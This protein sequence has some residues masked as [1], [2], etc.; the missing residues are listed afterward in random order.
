M[1]PPKQSPLLHLNQLKRPSLPTIHMPPSPLRT[2]NTKGTNLSHQTDLRHLLL[3]HPST[4]LFGFLPANLPPL[5]K[6]RNLPS[7]SYLNT[8][9]DL[10]NRLFI[11]LRAPTLMLRRRKLA[12]HLSTPTSLRNHIFRPRLYRLKY[13]IKEG[14]AWHMLEPLPLSAMLLLLLVH[15]R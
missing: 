10:V 9:C 13:N 5:R 11:N 7:T 1:S 4:L 12:L 8:L 14:Q 6:T 3:A 15:S 2:L